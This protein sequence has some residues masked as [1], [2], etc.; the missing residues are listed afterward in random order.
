MFSLQKIF[1]EY[2]Q[3]FAITYVGVSLMVIFLP[4][5]VCKEWIGG[6]LAK[7]SF[8]KSYNS[9]LLLDPLDGLDVPLRMNEVNHNPKEALK[10]YPL[11]D[12]D[13]NAAEGGTLMS[14]DQENEFPLLEKT[15][16]PTSWEIIKYSFCLAPVWFITEV[17]TYARF[18]LLG[19]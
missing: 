5:S 8:K 7:S 9:N 17:I 3:P 6:V 4:I 1:A 11:T 16:D 19:L 14:E 10:S 13:L 15:H 12:M 2:E 18:F